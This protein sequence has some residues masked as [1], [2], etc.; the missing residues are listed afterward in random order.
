MKK[1]VKALV[2]AAAITLLC[3]ISAYAAPTFSEFWYQTDDGIWHVMDETGETIKNCWFCDDAVASNGKDV[4]YFI[5]AFGNMVSYPLV[6]DGTG[7]TYSLETN[8][9]GYYGM[10]HYKDGSYSFDGEPIT[11][12]LDESHN[13]SFGA[14]ENADAIA[15]LAVKYGIKNVVI[16]NS[17]IKYSSDFKKAGGSGAQ[18]GGNAGGSSNQGAGPA[19]DPDETDEPNHLESL[20]GQTFYFDGK[21]YV[22][23]FYWGEHYLT[24]YSDGLVT[25]SGTTPR[26]GRT[27]AGPSYLLGRVCYIRRVSGVRGN[28]YDGVYHFE[29]TGGTA[30]E[31]G[32]ERTMGVPVVDIYFNSAAEVWR[33]SDPGWTTVEVYILKEK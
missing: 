33:L 15:A 21:E 16:D 6:Q 9:D 14:I 10:L 28:E 1:L 18:T 4:W 24:G 22:P 3:A 7:N 17:N 26:A 29:D 5:D 20:A 13:G 2:L 25:A 8:H 11:L 23:D 19:G 12:D 30:V 31:Y 32:L 27:I